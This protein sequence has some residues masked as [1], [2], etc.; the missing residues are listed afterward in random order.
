M[1][2]TAT[3]ESVSTQT[4]SSSRSANQPTSAT[5]KPFLWKARMTSLRV[6]CLKSLALDDIQAELSRQRSQAPDLFS[7][8]PLVLD[9][10]AVEFNGDSVG[11]LLALIDFLRGEQLCPVAV[12]SEQP[13]LRKAAQQ[14]GLSINLPGA[15]GIK[16]A[17]SEATA[18]PQ[19]ANA[20]EAAPNVTR[21]SRV[22]KRPVRSGQ[23]VYARGADLI[24]TAAVSAGAEI[25]ADG[26]IHCYGPLRG[27]AIAGAQ[28][29]ES[30]NLF[31]HH[32]EAELLAVAGVYRTSEQLGT[33]WQGRSVWVQTNG[34]RLEF[35]ALS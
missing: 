30:A 20:T 31:V 1:A 26:N 19:K 33:E 10:A 24:V 34:E 7:G 16:S 6:M 25:I 3:V 4:G 14:A 9:L 17:E 8:A 12:Q 23:Q 11:Q 35:S 29:D 32:C 15:A 27:K 22:V 13:E 5:A 2:A 18:K 28:G 21:P